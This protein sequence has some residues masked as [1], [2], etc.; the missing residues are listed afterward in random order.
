MATGEGENGPLTGG[1]HFVPELESIE[2]DL[3]RQITIMSPA[4]KAR[5]MLEIALKMVQE[6]KTS[7]AE[8]K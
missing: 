8:N 2:K 3:E 5:P 4:R 1:E 6:A 7:V